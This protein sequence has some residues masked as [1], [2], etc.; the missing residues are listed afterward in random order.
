MN[1]LSDRGAEV[2]ENDPQ[3]EMS[4]VG[5][6]NRG[7]PDA[8]YLRGEEWLAEIDTIMTSE[9]ISTVVDSQM[10]IETVFHSDLLPGLITECGA[11]STVVG[12]AWIAKWQSWGGGYDKP[13]LIPSQ[14]QFRFGNDCLYPSLGSTVLIG[15]IWVTKEGNVAQKENVSFHADVIAMDVPLLLSLQS[16][17][18]MKCKID[19]AESI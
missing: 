12:A 6:N 2:Q 7:D 18:K 4:V 13:E 14:K 3:G 9:E 1:I 10:N 11:A 8:A 19:F 5:A 16:I 17:Q 15:W